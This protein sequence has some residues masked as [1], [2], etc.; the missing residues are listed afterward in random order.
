MILNLTSHSIHLEQYEATVG[1]VMVE[2]VDEDGNPL[3]QGLLTTVPRVG[4]EVEL[5]ILPEVDPA[6]VAELGLKMTGFQIFK[7]LMGFRDKKLEKDVEKATEK[8]PEPT[9]RNGTVLH[10]KWTP[11]VASAEH[12]ITAA[13]V[14]LKMQDG[15][16]RVDR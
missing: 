7:S 5:I 3:Q 14:V 1:R 16:P 15:G 4:E 13:T 2:F 8:L 9:V 6:S 10:V 11:F 12:A